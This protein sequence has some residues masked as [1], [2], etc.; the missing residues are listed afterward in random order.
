MT[1]G[2]QLTGWRKFRGLSRNAF[3]RLVGVSRQTALAWESDQWAPS[4]EHRPK[5]ASVL[6][7]PAPDPVPSPK[8]PD[9]PA[10]VAAQR[11]KAS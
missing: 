2:Q 1:Y 10:V 9:P 7:I 6:G 8:L 11:A 3:A 5:I 4:E